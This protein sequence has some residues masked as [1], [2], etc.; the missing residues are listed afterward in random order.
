[1]MEIYVLTL[2]LDT[3]FILIQRASHKENEKHEKQEKQGG[4]GNVLPGARPRR[5]LG[6]SP[7][8]SCK[9]R[10]FSFESSVFCWHR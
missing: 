10:C 7:R 1:M 5:S 4:T 9:S 3:L 6:G 2:Y 8:P